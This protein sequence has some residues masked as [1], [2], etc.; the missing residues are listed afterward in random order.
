MVQPFLTEE[1]TSYLITRNTSERRYF[2][3]PSKELR[4][5]IQY[6]IA[7]A[8]ARH[9]VAIH[10][11]CAMSNHIHI[12][13]TDIDGTAPLFV[14]AMNQ[15]I[16]RYVNCTLGH[17]GAMW[18]GGARPNYCVLPKGGDV[19]DKVVYTLAN[20]VNAGLVKEHHLWPGAISNSAQIAAGRIITKRPKKYFS[21]TKDPKLITRELVLTPVPGAGVLSHEDYG[22]LIHERVTAEEARIAEEREVKKLPW[23][24]RRKCL[25]MDPYD[26]PEKPWTPF[27]RRPRVSSKNEEARRYRIQ[28]QKRFAELHEAAK[29]AFRDGNRDV[30]FPTGTFFLRVYFQ[31]PIEPFQ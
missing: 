12:V 9:P 27:S 16:A 25:A 4:D 11:F 3:R 8:Q 19:M 15:S 30:A 1:L 7:D 24:G 6:C 20:P 29:K 22:K 17:F 31:V 14:Q 2:L 26:A 13:I 18:E 10:A 5:A 28:R 21:K 23:M